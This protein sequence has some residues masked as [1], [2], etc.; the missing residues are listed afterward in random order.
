MQVALRLGKRR[1]CVQVCVVT[2]FKSYSF[3]RFWSASVLPT[4]YRLLCKTA[5]ADAAWATM[6][7]RARALQPSGHPQ[8]RLTHRMEEAG[9]TRGLSGHWE[10]HYAWGTLQSRNR[11]LRFMTP[12]QQQRRRWRWLGT[13]PMVMPDQG[14]VMSDQPD[15]LVIKQLDLWAKGEQGISFALTLVR[16]S[17]LSPTIFLRPS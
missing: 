11:H 4:E 15:C 16:L 9:R 5:L 6:S 8:E 17:T 12:S 1:L 10:I 13:V 7:P 14:S 2:G 3:K